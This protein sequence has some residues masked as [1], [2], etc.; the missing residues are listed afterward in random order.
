MDFLT[1]PNAKE[2]SKGIWEV[3][4]SGLFCLFCS[5]RTVPGFAWNFWDAFLHLQLDEPMA[6]VHQLR[7]DC[8]PL[9]QNSVLI[10]CILALGLRILPNTFPAS[11]QG[12][13]NWEAFS[14]LKEWANFLPRLMSSSNS[15]QGSVFWFSVFKRL[16]PPSC[17]PPAPSLLVL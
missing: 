3:I 10:N 8:L 12:K 1:L 15:L 4:V 17:L 9:A 16:S 7:P 14:P 5:S 11:P 13:G 2:H 6:F